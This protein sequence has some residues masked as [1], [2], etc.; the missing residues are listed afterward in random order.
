MIG[1]ICPQIPGVGTKDTGYIDKFLIIVLV[2]GLG[3]LIIYLF[4]VP[5]DRKTFFKSV[6]KFFK[7]DYKQYIK[8]YVKF[9]IISSLILAILFL[10]S[11]IL[12]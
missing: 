2:F 12:R 10:V 5:E 6:A 11:K 9:I 7:T 8:Y 1:Q 3:Y 4:F